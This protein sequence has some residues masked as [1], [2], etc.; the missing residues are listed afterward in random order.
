MKSE[1]FLAKWARWAQHKPNR[2]LAPTSVK[3]YG[4]GLKAL[5]AW[6]TDS[7]LDLAELSQGDLESFLA[8]RSHQSNG[9]QANIFTAVQSF[10]EYLQ[11]AGLRPDNPAIGLTFRRRPQPRLAPRRREPLGSQLAKLPPRDREIANFVKEL[12]DKDVSLLEIFSIEVDP[13][14]VVPEQVPVQNGRGDHRLVPL[15]PTA[16]QNLR[17]WGGRLPIG[18]RAFQRSLNNVG[19]TPKLLEESTRSVVAIELHPKLQQPVF[20]QLENGEF[21]DAIARTYVQLRNRL[22]QLHGQPEDAPVEPFLDGVHSFKPSLAGPEET[23]NLRLLIRAALALFGRPGVRDELATNDSTMAKE[24]V[25][26]GDMLLRILEDEDSRDDN[27]PPK[28]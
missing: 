6:A 15:S 22:R 21:S 27:L 1:D 13:P 20:E 9:T 18:I 12:R 23:N 26:L 24:V 4:S 16:R 7:S 5:A 25:F 2:P 19:L 3:A 11:E 14:G 10:Y 17:K 28:P 8:S